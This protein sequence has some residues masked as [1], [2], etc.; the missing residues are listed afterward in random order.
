MEAEL[1]L[2][3]EGRKI[4]FLEELREGL[5]LKDKLYGL[6]ARVFSKTALRMGGASSDPN[7]PAIILFTSGSEGL[8][9]GVS[10]PPVFLG[11]GVCAGKGDRDGAL[12]CT[13]RN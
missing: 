4:I 5:V 13:G 6:F 1:A 3:A 10:A 12:A 8:P 7:A 11:G 2:L 9:K